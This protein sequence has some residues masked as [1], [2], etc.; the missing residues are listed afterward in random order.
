MAGMLELN[1]D[2]KGV[3]GVSWFYD[4]QVALI[5]PHLAYLLTPT[6]YGAFLA[7]MGSD[8]HHIENAIV[9]SSVRR[10]LYEEGRYL[11]TCYL[12]A[13]PRR[14]LIAW[15]HRLRAEPS[16]CFRNADPVAVDHQKAPSA[17]ESTTPAL[18]PIAPEPTTTVIA[19]TRKDH[20]VVCSTD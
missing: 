12:L 11:P 5:S 15:A 19:K 9:R 7:R 3:A 2:V 8:R 4:P 18:N 14:A 1:P 10:R 17:T 13:W 20:E 16:A 6:H